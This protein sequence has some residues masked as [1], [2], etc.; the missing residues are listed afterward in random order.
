LGIDEGVTNWQFEN[1]NYKIISIFR[2]PVLAL[3]KSTKKHFVLW[4]PATIYDWVEK[5]DFVGN[6][7]VRLYN[8]ESNEAQYEIDI[9]NREIKLMD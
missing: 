1:N 7:V 8:R 2:G 5:V 6:D 4:V 9:K 3:D